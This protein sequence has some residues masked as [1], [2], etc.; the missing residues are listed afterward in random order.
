MLP[1]A[2]GSSFVGTQPA[3]RDL[4]LYQQPGSIANQRRGD[5]DKAEQRARC[6]SCVQCSKVSLQR[7]MGQCRTKRSWMKPTFWLRS[8]CTE[9]AATRANMV[10]SLEHDVGFSSPSSESGS[11]SGSGSG[12]VSP[13]VRGA[14]LRDSFVL[15][16]RRCPGSAGP[17]FA[18]GGDSIV[19]SMSRILSVSPPTPAAFLSFTSAACARIATHPFGSV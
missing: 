18:T 10:S 11:G 9:S 5:S 17:V 6:A 8:C 16:G 2:L 7:R 4:E 12:C 13:L 15:I 14:C 19:A 1:V 3:E